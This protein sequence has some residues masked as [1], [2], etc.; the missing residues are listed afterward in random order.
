MLPTELKLDM[1]RFTLT[2]KGKSE[3][4]EEQYSLNLFNFLINT[5]DSQDTVPQ[6]LRRGSR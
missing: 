5:L 1:M 2:N 3:G 4:N 6:P